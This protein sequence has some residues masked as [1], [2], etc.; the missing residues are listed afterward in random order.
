MLK[1]KVLSNIFRKIIGYIVNINNKVRRGDHRSATS[2][3]HQ[4]RSFTLAMKWSILTITNADFERASHR[5]PLV[6]PVGIR[7]GVVLRRVVAYLNLG[8]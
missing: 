7:A 4:H 2:F 1:M 3:G 8:Y 6:V 5:R